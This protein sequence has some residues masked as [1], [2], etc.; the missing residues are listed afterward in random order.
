MIRSC[1]ARAALI[2]WGCFSHR[3]VLPSMSVK[4]KVTTL[5]GE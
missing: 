3:W 4:R 2:A 1:R 5:S